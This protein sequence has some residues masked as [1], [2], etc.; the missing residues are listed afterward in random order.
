MLDQLR[1]LCTPAFLYFLLSSLSIMTILLQNVLYG[2]RDTYCI[3]SYRCHMSSTLIPFLGKIVYMLLVTL[4]LNEL[5]KRGY[6][7]ISWLIFLFPFIMMFVLI[8][9]F[10][11]SFGTL[12]SH[13]SHTQQLKH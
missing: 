6:S 3:G 9:S 5:C 12:E 7:N 2:T 13:Y 1:N 10:M 4:G 11:L 8:G